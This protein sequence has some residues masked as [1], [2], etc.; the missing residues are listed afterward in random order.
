MAHDRSPE[1]LAPH[2]AYLLALTDQL[3]GLSA[4]QLHALFALLAAAALAE[5]APLCEDAGTLLPDATEHPVTHHLQ[6]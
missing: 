1:A 2:R 5:G 6:A 4:A 3:E